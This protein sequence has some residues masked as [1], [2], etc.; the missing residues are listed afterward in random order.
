MPPF[1]VATGGLVVVR[2]WDAGGWDGLDLSSRLELNH[3]VPAKQSETIGQGSRPEHFRNNMDKSSVVQI[4]GRARN[5]LAREDRPATS[6]S[7]AVTCEA[8]PTELAN[9]NGRVSCV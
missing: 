7:G 4:L 5:E 6:S 9:N 2:A 3:N 1:K 8:R